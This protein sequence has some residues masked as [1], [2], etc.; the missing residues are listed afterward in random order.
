MK[1]YIAEFIGTFVLVFM[2]C[3][4]AVLTGGFSG[5]AGV[6]GIALSFGLAIVAMAYSIG[7]ISGCHI[8]PAVSLA[9]LISR[10]MVFGDFVGYVLAQLAGGIAGA[11]LLKVVTEL[12]VFTGSS[13]GANGYGEQSATML[14]MA[15]ALIVEIVLTFIFILTILGVTAKE[16]YSKIAGLVIGLA[17]TFVHLI[18][19][20]LTGTS[21]N[22]ARSIGP[23]LFAGGAAL[24]QLWVFIVGPLLG[25]VAAALVWMFLTWEK[26]QKISEKQ[27]AILTTQ[28]VDFQDDDSGDPVDVSQA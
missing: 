15:G 21:V 8:N 10:R 7:Q 28:I 12:T 18:G 3:G 23:A 1:K 16:E 14:P 17:L 6:T 22:P 26:N 4:T 5:V 24:S 20:T 11:G 25:A 19:I 13:L 2:C 27:E 9:M